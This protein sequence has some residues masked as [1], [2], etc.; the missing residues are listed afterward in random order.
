[1]SRFPDI[2]WH[3]DRCNAELN[4]QIGFDDYKYLWKCTEC[5]FKNSI[6]RDNIYPSEEAFRME[7]IILIDTEEE[8]F[9]I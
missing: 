8:N 1:M 2:V 4:N 3:C 7:D 9:D 5:G 6:S